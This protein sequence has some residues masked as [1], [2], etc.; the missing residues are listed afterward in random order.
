MS[1][2]DPSLKSTSFTH[3]ATAFVAVQELVGEVA[4]MAQSKPNTHPEWQQAY[5]IAEL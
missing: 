1:L 2:Q 5:L 3:S 4:L